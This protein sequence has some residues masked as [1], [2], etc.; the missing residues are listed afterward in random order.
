MILFLQL[1]EFMSLTFVQRMF[2]ASASCFILYVDSLHATWALH[3]VPPNYSTPR[4]ALS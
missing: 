1:Q 2:R 3:Q 4:F